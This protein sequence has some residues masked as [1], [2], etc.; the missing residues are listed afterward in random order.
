MSAESQRDEVTPGSFETPR[1]WLFPPAL[2]PLVRA[3]VS[4]AQPCLV[5]VSDEA[6]V[7]LL[8][9]VFFA[10]LETYEGEHY[11]V[12]VAFAGGL[13][14]DV[15][16]SNDAAPDASPMLLYRWSTLRLD[17]PRP[18]CVAEL[19]KLGVVTRRERMF[20]KVEHTP[21]GLKITGL[22]RE[23][24]NDDD[25]DPYVEV[26]SPRP[27]VLTIRSGQKCIVEYERGRCLEPSH[28]AV[29]P[30]GLIRR[31]LERAAANA[32]VGDA[33]TQDYLR[34]V[35]ALVGEMV[36]HGKGGILIISR[37]TQPELPASAAYRTQ[38][39]TAI[40]QLVHYLDGAAAA[41][42]AGSN[43]APSSATGAAMQL[44]QVLRSAF[45]SEAERW[46]SEFGAFTAMDGATVLDCALGLRGFG[47]VLP[48]AKDI[49]MMEATDAEGTLLSAYDLAT[50]GTRHR[51]AANYAEKYPGSVVFVA[52]QD[53]VVSC[54]LAAGDNKQVTLW[55]WGAGAFL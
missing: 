3:R 5:G 15:L 2:V 19:V 45:L 38:N 30:Q 41:R 7:N 37:D 8:T 1:A 46:V 49:K 36:T 18:F 21:D 55:R 13:R 47:V 17:P 28:D 11:P 39:D 40:A 33:S 43:L 16:M 6:L 20:T 22:A 31:A 9:V 24:T 52:S 29:L 35:R 23:G 50:R 25:N 54:L 12:R 10:G 26:T 27:G 4:R 34:M 32:Q 53:G 14:A 48:V 42:R 44:R 51:A